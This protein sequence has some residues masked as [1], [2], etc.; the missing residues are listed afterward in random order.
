MKF[1]QTLLPATLLRRYKRFLADVRL[2]D[3]TLCTVH[4]PNSGSMAG[5]GVEGSPVLLSRAANPSRKYPYTWE[6]VY[7]NGGWVGINTSRTNH[8]VREAFATGVVGEI[9]PVDDIRAEVKVSDHSRLDLLL[10]QGE[11][12]IY[13]EVKNCT[14]VENG[15]AMFPD[16]VTVRGARHLEELAALRRQGFG[17]VIFFCVQRGDGEYFSPAAH[18]DP[19][20]A[21]T[22]RR[23]AAEGVTVLAYRA[24]VG[25]EAIRVAKGLPVRL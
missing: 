1:E 24:E 16:A 17:A 8:L 10:R 19:V 7:V 12:Q 25:P 15:V 3:G 2:A 18:I 14:L 13:V 21:A 5:C 22:L 4:C 6:M 23:V 20:Y 11:R 9:G